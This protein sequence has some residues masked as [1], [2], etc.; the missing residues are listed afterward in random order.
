MMIFAIYSFL[1][2]DFNPIFKNEAFVYLTNSLKE[3]RKE[4]FKSIVEIYNK[5]HKTV[6]E[7]RR[8]FF[9]KLSRLLVFSMSLVI[10]FT[11]LKFQYYE[12]TIIEKRLSF[13][14]NLA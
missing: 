4:N 14:Y 2:S 13:D 5:T 7:K 1:L 6:K 3:T 10:A 11:P 9:L 12:R 8:L